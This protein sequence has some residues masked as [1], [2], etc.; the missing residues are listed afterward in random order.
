[1]CQR[2]TVLDLHMGKAS[3]TRSTATFFNS[4]DIEYKS[5]WENVS[6]VSEFSARNSLLLTIDTKQTNLC[7]LE[8]LCRKWKCHRTLK[9]SCGTPSTTEDKSP[10]VRLRGTAFCLTCS[11]IYSRSC[12]SVQVYTTIYQ[13]LV[14]TISKIKYTKIAYKYFLMESL[15]TSSRLWQNLVR[16][17]TTSSL[18]PFW[19]KK[20]NHFLTLSGL[21]MMCR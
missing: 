6:L 18:L 7:Q 19:S 13:F 21:F 9:E 11:T 1:M 8:F 16:D 10:E 15:Y 5:L 17:M 2:L 20:C 14:I 12:R 4:F 3:S